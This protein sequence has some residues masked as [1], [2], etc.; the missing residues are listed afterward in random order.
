M[1]DK[2]LFGSPL[3]QHPDPAQRVSGVAALPPDAPALVQLLDADPA[4]EVRS[5]AAARSTDLAALT[6][7]LQREA[8]PQVRATI[9]ASLGRL[10]AALPDTEAVV[11]WL[12]AP[13][14]TDAVRAALAL[15]ADDPKR[16]QLALAGMQDEALLA[17]VALAAT[18]APLRLAAAERVHAAAPLQRL[19][20]AF[21]DR[22]RGVAR[23]ARHRLDTLARRAKDAATADALIAQA[24]AL[25]AQPGA[26]VMA[27]VELDRRWNVLDLGDDAE[28]RARWAQIGAR[29]QQRFDAE[30]AAQQAH[31]RLEQ[32]V[33][34][35]LA[36][37]QSQ[38]AT[39]ALPA[40]R[41]GWQALHEEA[42]QV[43]DAP[44]L[45]RL[46]QAD[47]QLAQWEAAAPVLAAAEALVAE[48]EELAAGTSIDDAQLPARWQAIDAAARTPALA[49]RVEAAL[50]TIEQRRLAHARA[51]Q[52]A[53][54][55][56]RQRLH[57]L[58]H[59][60]EQALAAG[61]LHEARAALDEARA[62][63]PGAGL[64][65]KPTVQRLSRAL[66][67]LGEMERWEKFGQQ[68][69]RVQLC[70]RAEA[71]AAQTLTPAALARDV[72]QLRA[73]WK[74]LDAQYA[75]VPK[76]L[77][78][79]FDG[80]CEKAY[81][82]AA[83]HFAALAAQHKQARQA[84]EAFIA[85]A[86]TQA[87]AQ[88]AEP[89]DW[90]AIEHWLR[91]TDATW[92]GASLGSVEPGAWKKLDTRMKAAVAPLRAAL[93]EARKEAK[94]VRE[95]LIAEAEGWVARAQEREAPTQVKELQARWQTAA[96][97]MALLQR[98]ERALW[99]KFRAACNAV[100]DARK[101]GRK[102]ADQQKHV[103]RRAF[104]ALCEQAE[105]VA[106]ATDLDEA[107]ARQRL[108][109]LR[110][111]WTQAQA[112]GGPAPAPLDSRFRAARSAFDASLKQRGRAQAAAGLR[113][114]LDKAALCDAL[115]ALVAGDLAGEP[116]AAA[117]DALQAQWAALPGLEADWERGLDGRRQ[118]ALA[119]LADEDARDDHR[120]VIEDAA[121]RRV[122][123]LLEIE[124]Q[125][126]L[127]SPA[128]LQAQRRA[129][130]VRQLRERFKG[131]AADG[132]GSAARLLVDWC[133]QPGTADARDRERCM[134]I[135]A[136]LS[137]R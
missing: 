75:G 122:D 85:A 41:A 50:R 54:G 8:E 23:L 5:A 86:E 117:V 114:L 6:A 58:L 38:P 37:L 3:H 65:P 66:Q 103:Q 64:L 124:L 34:A 96:K 45:A 29:M 112:A 56:S 80:A 7:A 15:G 91:D 60:A 136:A 106:R 109:E 30:R 98:D 43:G 110:E 74:A 12:A 131:N 118:A 76:A 36:A 104:E 53:Q 44:A 71:L 68:T 132:G 88:L 33:D 115:D 77:W 27:A 107:Q 22:D 113:A 128:D 90:R 1:F 61:Q 19:F 108:R 21:N 111:Q 70:E 32:R 82:P 101:N 13:H 130:Q 87:Q 24:E 94:A 125:L 123:L 48:A 46:A 95:S 129:V 121:P 17:D 10:L 99:E 49:Q 47:A 40:L 2:L 62:L 116:L 69:A 11:A 55:G 127:Q 51:E 92:H 73:E 26:I 14:C 81:A 31:A 57:A 137:R 79:R 20:D 63:K 102:E 133:L 25:V 84:R 78:Q 42:Q 18:H 97:S 67:Q 89:R 72:Q 134:E 119:A 9:A 100:F 93:G 135:V 16:Q 4:P 35:W 105:Q 83:A 120:Y 126:G 28:R 39:D 59:S 52:E